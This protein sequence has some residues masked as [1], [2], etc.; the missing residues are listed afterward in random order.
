[1]NAKPVVYDSFSAAAI[2][3]GLLGNATT[4]LLKTGSTQENYMNFKSYKQVQQVIADKEWLFWNSYLCPTGTV[5]TVRFPV[6][7]KA[8]FQ[9]MFERVI[10]IITKKKRIK[11]P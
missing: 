4:K 11:P 6:S 5:G 8:S 7:F 1:M 3:F 2:N 9:F 10:G